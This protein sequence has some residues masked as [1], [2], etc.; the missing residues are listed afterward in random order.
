L[1]E[2]LEEAKVFIK[3]H[4]WKVRDEDEKGARW[5]WWGGGE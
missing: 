4:W 2:F 3:I 5:W 1:F